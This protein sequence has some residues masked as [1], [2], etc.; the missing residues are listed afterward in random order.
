M[1]EGQHL[2]TCYLNPERLCPST[3]TDRTILMKPESDGGR[4]FLTEEP[5]RAQHVADEL[6]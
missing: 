4:V 1:N 5:D 6:Y 2:P 3:R